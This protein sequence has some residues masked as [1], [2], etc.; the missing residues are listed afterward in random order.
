[1]TTLQ[2]A[3]THNLVAVLSKPAESEGFEQIVD[4][5][6][7]NLIRYVLTINPTIYTSCIEQFWSTGKAKTVNGEVQLQ[8]LV[9][10]KK[11]IVTEASI[12]SDLQ[13]DDKEGMDC[14]PNATIFV[15]HT[16][17][18]YEKISQKHTF[19][20][21]FF[22]PQW[23]FLIHTIL[24]CL[25][26]KTTAWNEFSS[27]MASA[28]IYEAINEEIDG[29]LVRVSSTAS[30]LE[31][32][33]DSDN[34]IKTRSKATPN[35]P[36]SLGTSS[37]GGSRRQET[38][39]DT[40]AQ[41]GFENVSKTS[42]DSLLAGTSQAQEIISLKR[43]VKRL[44][45]KNRSKT[46]GLKRLYKVGLSA[47][48][49]SSEDKGLGEEDASKQGR[50]D[51]IDTNE[52]IYLVNVH[53]DEDMFGVNDLEGDEVIVETEVDHEVVVETEVAFKDV[54]LSVDEV[55]LAQALASLKSA[56]PKADKTQAKGLVIHE[57]EQETT[58]TISSQ[59]PS[60]VKV[61]DK[62]KGIMVE[63]PLKMKKKDQISFDEQ[64]AIRLQAEFDEEERLT[65][66]KAHEQ[67]ELT[68]EE[69]ARLFVQ[70]LEQRRKHFAAKGAKE[71]RNRPTTR[72]QQRSIMCT[73]L[74]N[75]EGWK[76]KRLKNK[77]FD[78]I[79][80]L[81]DKAFKR[82]NTFVDYR[83]NSKR[84]GEA[85]EQESSKKKKVEE[86]KESE[87]LKQCLEIIPDDGDDVIV[88]AK[89]LSTKSPTIVD[90]KIYKEVK[91]SNFQSIRVDVKARFKKTKP[92]NYMDN[93]LLLNLKTMFE[94]HVEDTSILYYL[95][96]EKM[97]QLT[98]HTLHQMF[99]DVKLQVDYECKMTFELLRLVKK[100]VK[101][102]YVPK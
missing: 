14:L 52:D 82:V 26:S 79:Q 55:T 53:R 92:V 22:S 89:P 71:K 102:G 76:P 95:L 38:M 50:I 59:Q 6:N 36:S 33:Q 31:A 45:K 10:G 42:N 60:Q 93:F 78:N 18:G 39:G 11:I 75:M 56:K 7:A 86:G 94:H 3:D 15:D 17:M 47:R 66:E 62:G 74:K 51:D 67:E 88:D 98:N 101:E 97:Y 41:T 96:V 9:D 23:K 69:K 81:F 48:I 83:T 72:S 2:F 28:I 46:H 63:E 68:D 91:K 61:M 5:L 16:R 34:T 80:E 29:S 24:Q 90:Y 70:F 21:A 8:A 100:Q 58:P 73:Y 4:F 43:R 77:S 99:N 1:M 57:E 20:K 87:E 40:I 13:L 12:R 84:A 32:E 35:E 54:N 49:K 30:S 37:G 27:T 65:R 25:S 85:L 64:E 19:Y 44:E